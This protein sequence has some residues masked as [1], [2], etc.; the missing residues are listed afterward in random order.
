MGTLPIRPA[1]WAL[2]GSLPSGTALPAEPSGTFCRN[3]LSSR[4][5]SRSERRLRRPNLSA[6][7]TFFESC[8]IPC[9]ATRPNRRQDGDPGGQW[10]SGSRPCRGQGSEI[11]LGPKWTYGDFAPLAWGSQDGKTEI[12]RTT[13]S[14]NFFDLQPSSPDRDGPFRLNDGPAPLGADRSV[15]TPWWITTTDLSSHGCL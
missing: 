12:S 14:A 9:R 3:S 2:N 5:H 13:S 15:A 8:S 7:L 4:E 6:S 11:D 1:A 10:P